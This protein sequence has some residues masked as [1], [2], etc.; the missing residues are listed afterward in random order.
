M[1]VTEETQIAY[2]DFRLRDFQAGGAAWIADYNDANSFLY[3]MQSSTGSQNYGDYKSPAFDALLAKSDNEPDVKRRAADLAQAEQIMV[4]DAT[5]APLYY[6]V[7]KN[8]VNPRV[9]GWVDNITDWHRSRL[10]CVKGR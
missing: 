9:T 1:L 10:L 7:S 2:Q 6:Y 8:L 5:V 4:G 3:L